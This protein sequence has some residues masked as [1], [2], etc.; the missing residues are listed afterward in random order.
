MMS[1]S[2]NPWWS[3]ICS[4]MIIQ[5]MKYQHVPNPTSNNSRPLIHTIFRTPYKTTLNSN[6]SRNPMTIA[7]H[8]LSY[9]I[10]P[11]WTPSSKYI[12]KP[13]EYQHFLKHH[14][15]S[16]LCFIIC[17]LAM[18]HT[19]FRMPHKKMK[20]QQFIKSHDYSTQCFIICSLAV[21]V[22]PP[23]CPE[24]AQAVPSG[25]PRRP[26]AP[27]KTSRK[28]QNYLKHTQRHNHIVKTWMK[29]HAIW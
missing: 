20:D 29:T 26:Q 17:S 9:A 11:W 16:T 7:H 5:P 28:L 15:H 23:R 13:M 19:L 8:V 24:D 10:L 4:I 2:Q 25:S 27:R 21:P 1:S 14:D 12:I 6:N 22:A 3:S 18:I